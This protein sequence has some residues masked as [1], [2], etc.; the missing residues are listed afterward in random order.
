MVEVLSPVDSTQN[1]ADYKAAVAEVEPLL[2]SE[3]VP[4]SPVYIRAMALVE[5]IDAYETAHGWNMD[6]PSEFD[7]TEF[8]LD[9]MGFA[10]KSSEI[11]EATSEA[12]RNVMDN[13]PR[14][15]D[16]AN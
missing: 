8:Q 14:A 11:G 13:T 10:S 3:P 15:R 16:G 5:A 12:K 1:E 9:Q 7:L 6:E 4:D 2:A